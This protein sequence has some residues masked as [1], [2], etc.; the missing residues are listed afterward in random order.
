MEIIAEIGTGHRND[1]TL[2]KEL[3]FAASESGAST[4]KF[5]HALADEI[6]HK[7]TGFVDLPLG[8]VRL[9]DEFKK[10]ESSRDFFA[11]LKEETE[12]LGKKFLLSVFGIRSLKDYMS[13]YPD[14]VKVA[15]PELNHIVLLR[16]IA[17][18]NIKIILSLG[19]SKLKDIEMALDIVGRQKTTLLHCVTSYPAPE[20]EYNMLLLITLK[21]IFGVE[22]GLSDHSL[23]PI[24]LPALAKFLGGFALEKHFTLSNDQDGLDDKIA[25]NPDNFSKMTKFLSKITP[26]SDIKRLGALYGEIPDEMQILC[27]EFGRERIFKV[28]GSGVKTFAKSEEVNYTRTNR[29]IHALCSIKKGEKFTFENVALLRTEKVLKV[30]LNPMFYD[31]ILGKTAKRDVEDGQGIELEDFVD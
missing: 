26:L 4:V 6:I 8:R 29:S 12:K 7:N 31:L 15:S 10:L 19:V 3:V 11:T 16:E 28:L 17:K 23:D 22:V 25:L 2:A 1:L 13:L 24:F 14:R 20:E 9:Y 18:Q 30:G 21:S 5:Q 27:S